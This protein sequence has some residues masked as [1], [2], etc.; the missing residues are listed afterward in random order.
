MDGEVQIIGTQIWSALMGIV[1]SCQGNT[2][3]NIHVYTWDPHDWE[4]QARWPPQHP[5]KS[6]VYL[7]QIFLIGNLSLTISQSHH[8]L[9]RTVIL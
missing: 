6:T 3:H 1:Q 7:P 2:R 9:Q 5:V 4:A 8:L